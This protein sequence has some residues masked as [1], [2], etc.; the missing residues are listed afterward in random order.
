MKKRPPL[1]NAPPRID[2]PPKKKNLINSPGVYSKH[3]GIYDI[4]GV[5][6]SVVLV[7]PS[8]VPIKLNELTL[9]N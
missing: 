1:L 3:Y 2:S 7:N 8:F 4:Y 6:I 5:Y 9:M